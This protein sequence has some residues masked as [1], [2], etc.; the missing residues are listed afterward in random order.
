MLIPRMRRDL[1]NLQHRV[2]KHNKGRQTK[3]QGDGGCEYPPLD[4]A[5]ED[6]G[7]EEMGAYVMKKHITIAQ[8]LA[9][10]L[11]MDLCEETVRS[12]GA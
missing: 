11:I 12:P 4:I 5:M 8:Y 3:Q 1:G 9:T 6:E 10:R 7:F 2:A